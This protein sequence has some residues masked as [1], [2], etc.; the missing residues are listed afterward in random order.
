MQPDLI[1][2][3]AFALAHPVYDPT[4]QIVKGHSWMIDREVSGVLTVNIGDE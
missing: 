3:R 4:S 2:Q 1:R